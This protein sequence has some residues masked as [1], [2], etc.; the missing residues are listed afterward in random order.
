MGA[1]KFLKPA[2]WHSSVLFYKEHWHISSP[3]QNWNIHLQWKS[4]FWLN[5]VSFQCKLYQPKGTQTESKLNCHLKLHQLCH[6]RTLWNESFEVIPRQLWNKTKFV[7][8][9]QSKSTQLKIFWS[10]SIGIQYCSIIAN[11]KSK[12]PKILCANDLDG[13]VDLFI[14]DFDIF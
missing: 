1:L 7:Q 2:L 5:F 13:R 9:W 10:S 11:W 12:Q 6:Q 4:S 3:T 14:A 8:F